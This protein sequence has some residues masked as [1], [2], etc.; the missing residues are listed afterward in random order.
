MLKLE[1]I[2]TIVTGVPVQEASAEPARFMRLSDL[3]DI[4]AGRLP[5]LAVGQ[6][7]NVARALTIEV[8][9]LVIGARGAVTDVCVA[10]PYLEGVFISLD[11]YLVRPNRSYVDPH[12]LAAFLE[13]P[14]TQALLSGG[15][16]GTGLARLAKEALAKMKVPLPPMPQQ[17]LIACLAQSYEQETRLLKQLADIKTFFG[18]EA[19]TRAIRAAGIDTDYT[20]SAK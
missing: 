6:S 2:S 12:Y 20:G 10:E 4:K 5:T 13:L 11:L 14:T 8:G 1:K 7:P 18:R 17:R 9:D 16:Q 19:I 15:K 3:T